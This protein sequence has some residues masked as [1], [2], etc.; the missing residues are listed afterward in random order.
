MPSPSLILSP[1]SGKQFLVKLVEFLSFSF[2][3]LISIFSSSYFSF[4]H[5]FLPLFTFFFSPSPSLPSVFLSTFLHLPSHLSSPFPSM[6]LLPYSPVSSLCFHFPA[7][8]PK[9]FQ[10]TDGTHLLWDK[11]RGRQSQGGWVAR[12]GWGG[13]C[14]P[15]VVTERGDAL[16]SLGA[17]R[18]KLGT[19][20]CAPRLGIELGR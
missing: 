3:A 19:Q 11:P 20:V 2:T 1:A 13:R 18:G 12:G 10:T 5:L 16:L 7:K 14:H 6:P 4:S 8:I 9:M 17:N 15:Q